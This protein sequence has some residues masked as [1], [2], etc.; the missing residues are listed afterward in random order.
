MGSPSR[1]RQGYDMSMPKLPAGTYKCSIG[2]S[3]VVHESTEY[4]EADDRPAREC[5]VCAVLWPGLATEMKRVGGT[6][7]TH[8]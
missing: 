4:H 7:A 3:V 8:T 6:D 5:K 1:H 2:H